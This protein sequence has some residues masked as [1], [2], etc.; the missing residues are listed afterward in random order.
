ML[1][2]RRNLSVRPL[3]SGLW[4]T[5]RAF[6]LR[7]WTARQG[8]IPPAGRVRTLPARNGSNC[9]CPRWKACLKAREG[10]GLKRLPFSVLAPANTGRLWEGL[11]AASPPRRGVL[12]IL[13]F[14][15][16]EE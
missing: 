11:T 15:R 5:I 2:R 16:S 8:Y 10:H 6:V 7:P 13:G 1:S 4:E 12:P 3:A 14:L 9:L